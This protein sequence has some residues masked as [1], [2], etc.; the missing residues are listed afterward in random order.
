MRLKEY[1]QIKSLIFHL[2]IKIPK[3]IMETSLA[4]FFIKGTLRL[5]IFAVEATQ[6]Q[7][8]P[9]GTR[10]WLT[11]QLFDSQP[12][13]MN[14][15]SRWP[16]FYRHYWWLSTWILHQSMVKMI[17]WLYGNSKGRIGQ[18]NQNDKLKY[19]TQMTHI[20]VGVTLLEMGP[21]PTRAYFWLALNKRLS[22]LWPR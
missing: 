13:A 17:G 15:W 7:R 4:I 5:G 8:L 14:T 2:R 3:Q 9:G 21:D 6:G 20:S 12:D 11:P 19:M 10:V 18:Q 16:S 22:G 1:A